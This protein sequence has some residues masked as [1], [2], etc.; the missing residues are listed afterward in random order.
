MSNSG[1]EAALDPVVDVLGA[2]HAMIIAGPPPGDAGAVTASARL[3]QADFARFL[4]P[5]AGRLMAPLQGALPAGR[6]TIASQI[7]PRHFESSELYNEI[8]RPAG[9][10]YS[11][12]AR[13]AQPGSPCFVAVCR[14]RRAG[15]FEARDAAILQ[16]L[17]P[18]LAMAIDLHGR[19]RAAEQG[20]RQLGH[21][22]DRLDAGVI[23]TD[24]GARPIFVNA[25]AE[26]LAAA[27]G[28]LRLDHQGLSGATPKATQMLRAA[29]ASVG[30]GAGA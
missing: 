27:E 30:A 22:L 12:G 28:G 16:A 15:D 26:R 5:Q 24:A 3:H 8:L 14:S 2:D 17:L 7:S 21:V 9:G 6:A 23:L 4:S 29:I 1:W 18:H 20:R 10:F 19:L 25:Y 13:N 11:I